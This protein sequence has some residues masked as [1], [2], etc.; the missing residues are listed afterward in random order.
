[1]RTFGARSQE[2]L[3]GVHPKLV[4]LAPFALIASPYD[5]SI[6]EGRRALERQRFLFDNGD[7]DTMDSKHLAQD[8]GY[9]HALDFMA[10]G[11]LNGDGLI[12]HQDKSIAWNRELYTAIWSGWQLSALSL[13]ILVR[14][15]GEFKHHNGSPY[16]D[17]PHLELVG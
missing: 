9:S 1:M 15:G 7:S 5:F 4:I 3:L 6:I 12:N 2:N 8:D 10:S 13:G 16:F 11:D 14:W 17:G